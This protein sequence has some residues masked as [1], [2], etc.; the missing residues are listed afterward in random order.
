[1]SHELEE[2]V[3]AARSRDKASI[4]LPPTGNDLSAAVVYQIGTRAQFEAQPVINAEL[5]HTGEIIKLATPSKQRLWR[6]DDKL[7]VTVEVPDTATVE[8]IAEIHD[9]TT[10]YILI[11]SWGTSRLFTKIIRNTVILELQKIRLTKARSILAA[12]GDVS[13]A[14]KARAFVRRA[15]IEKSIRKRSAKQL[16]GFRKLRSPA[17][18]VGRRVG[19]AIAK[20]ALKVFFFVGLAVDIILIS[21]RFV[22]GLQSQGAAGGVGALVGGIAD[23]LT[24]GLLEEQTQELEKVTTNVI[25]KAAESSFFKVDFNKVGLVGG[26]GGFT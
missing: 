13:E 14:A 2:L 5:L 22:R 21:A 9:T 8:Q 19:R 1:M 4:G 3:K 7:L 26:S 12:G 24:L 23:A 18:F 10:R 6:V 25:I 16:T 17:R 20:T 11:Q 15:R